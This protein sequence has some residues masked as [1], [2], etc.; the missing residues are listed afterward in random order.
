MKVLILDTETTGLPKTKELN[1]E[2]LELWPY[3]VQFSYVIYDVQTNEM[4]K[5]RDAIAK[6]PEG[7]IMDDFNISIHGITNEQSSSEG[8]DL[9]K[10]LDEFIEDFDNVDLI[11]GHNLSFDLNVLRCE[12]MRKINNEY[13]CFEKEFYYEFLHMLKASNKLYCTM[14]ETID[15][16][17]IK[18]VNKYGKKYIK[19]PK[20]S[21]LHETLFQTSPK[22]LHN[23]LNDVMVC[24]RCY[25]KLQ[26]MFDILERN[27]LVKIMF[28]HLVG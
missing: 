5:V 22:N 17:K 6:L 1:D 3:I 14:M 24:L 28:E 12:L 2:T 11:V 19:Y 27:A 23:S 9:P 25:C 10:L 20:L 26:H 13:N 4:I 15:I 18:A 7:I 21:E 8:V 16:C